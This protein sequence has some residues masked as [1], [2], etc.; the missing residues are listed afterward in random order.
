M[1]DLPQG[2]HLFGSTGPNIL[3]TIAAA[4]AAGQFCGR[5]PGIMIGR[6]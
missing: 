6:A 4:A 5:R 3:A 2:R 1:A